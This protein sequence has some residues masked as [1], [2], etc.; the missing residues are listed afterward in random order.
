MTFPP[1][2]TIAITGFGVK[3]THRSSTSSGYVNKQRFDYRPYYKN[4][5]FDGETYATNYDISVGY[6]HYYGDAQD[7]ANTTWEWVGILVWPNLL[8][9][10]FLP[11][12]IA[13]YEYAASGG[14]VSNYTTG[15]IHRFLL[16]YA[17]D[18]DLLPQP[19]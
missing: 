7:K 10:G 1:A 15:W 17:L 18:T 3:V 8:P 4:S 16:T 6:E 2:G 14:D 9:E 12:Y 13:H 5:I 19:L 11:C